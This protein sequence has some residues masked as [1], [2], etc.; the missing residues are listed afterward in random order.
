MPLPVLGEAERKAGLE[1]LQPAFRLLLAEQGVPLEIQEIY[2]HFKINSFEIYAKLEPDEAS[3]RRWLKSGQGLGLDGEGADTRVT[4]SSLLVAWDACRDRVARRSALEAE[5]RASGRTPA[6]LRGDVLSLRRAY[7]QVRGELTDEDAPGKGYIELKIEGFHDGEVVAEN[8]TEVTS[9]A[10]EAKTPVP[11]AG[12]DVRWDQVLQLR[13]GKHSVAAP[14]TPEEFRH[15]VLLMKTMWSYLRLKGVAP[16]AL[17]KYDGSI[18][19]DYARYVLGPE[20]WS[21]ETKDASGQDIVKPSWAGLLHWEYQMRKAAVKLLNGGATL[22][23]ALKA[24]M[25]D[26]KVYMRYFLQPMSVAAGAD[27]AARARDGGSGGPQWVGTGYEPAAK[28]RRPDGDKGGSGKAKGRGKSTPKGGSGGKG[29]SGDKG[30][31]KKEEGPKHKFRE[32][33]AADPSSLTL[34]QGDKKVCYDFQNLKGCKRSNCSFL[35][36]CAWCGATDHGY[37]K[38]CPRLGR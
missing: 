6:L 33:K 4:L 27:A 38:P 20:G 11:G 12:V 21:M 23:E 19:D 34:A 5:Q 16:Q 2:G 25:K 13:T 7:E 14:R 32:Q 15:R 26:A 10:D 24:G 30:G 36:A 18:W 29:K 35:H 31:H 17:S 1:S 8:L 22:D 3:L 9:V 28:R 37:E